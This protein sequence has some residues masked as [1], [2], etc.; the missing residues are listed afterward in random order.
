ML[1]HASN[2]LNHSSNELEILCF[3]NMLEHVTL[4]AYKAISKIQT[5]LSQ[6]NIGPK[7]LSQQTLQ[8]S[9]NL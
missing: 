3:S 9:W 5:R 4:L 7:C 6:A 1:I 8:S 2:I